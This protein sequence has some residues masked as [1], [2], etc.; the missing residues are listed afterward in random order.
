M[1][2]DLGTKFLGDAFK[3]ETANPELIG[4]CGLD[5]DQ[6]CL[7]GLVLTVEFFLPPMPSQMPT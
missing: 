2:G 7:L 6:Y 3:K 4:T 5:L 1:E